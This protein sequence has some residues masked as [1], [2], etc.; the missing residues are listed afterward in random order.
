M[1]LLSQKVDR[2]KDNSNERT[3][4][5]MRAKIELIRVDN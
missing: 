2:I 3:D 4:I 1:Y 5:D